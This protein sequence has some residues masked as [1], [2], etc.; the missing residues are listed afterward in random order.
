VA[1]MRMGGN[2][3][4]QAMGLS[5][6]PGATSLLNPESGYAGDI[7]NTNYNARV[8]AALSNAQMKN[9]LIGAGISAV[10]SLGGAAMGMI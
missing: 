2:P 1:Q 8:G 4:S 7:Y 3:V 9:D 5:A 10:G 6:M